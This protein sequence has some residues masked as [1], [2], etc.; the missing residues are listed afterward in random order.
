MKNLRIF[1]A[2]ISGVVIVAMLVLNACT[3]G[4]DD[5]N[6]N[7]NQANPSVVPATTVL[8]SG[9]DVVGG[10]LYAE[11][12]GIFY[13]G[14]YAG[15]T[16]PI[17]LGDYEFR[18]DI[19]NNMWST[20]YRAAANFADAQDIASKNGNTNLAG[21]ALAM[22]AFTIHHITDM[23]GDV[24]YSQA[25]QLLTEAEIRDPEYDTQEEVYNQILVDLKEANSMLASGTGD[26]GTGDFVYAGNVSKWRKF[27][28][29]LR[30]RLAMRISHVAE[31]QAD[32]VVTEILGDPATYPIMENNADNAY[33]WW[34]GLATHAERWFR[35]VGALTGN[36]TTQYRMNNELITVL[37]NLGDPRLP[38]YADLNQYGEYNGYKMGPGQQTN[39]ENGGSYVSHIGNRFGNNPEGFSPFMNSAEVKFLLA[40]IYERNLVTG[41]AQQAYE[42]GVSL[43]LEENGLTGSDVTDYLAVDEVGWNSGVSSNL[44]KIHLQN[45]IALFKN[46]V[47]AWSNVR[48]TDVPLIMN[49]SEDF[50][51]NHNRPPLRLAYP[52]EEQA[53]NASFPNDIHARA[54]DTFYGFQVWWDTRTGIQ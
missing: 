39:V 27:I 21:V 34:P 13:A 9:F 20:M 17:G 50:A 33:I 48:R 5:L 29:S 6:V 45:W 54:S 10:I 3:S 25:F 7:P 44:Y 30:L 51:A 37:E 1:K 2:N 11:R 43:S 46:S 15:H 23:W 14:T 53:V 12:M 22:K 28:N 18:V 31:A 41:N 35:T 49:V 52:D 8:A 40:E 24:P 16:A 32:A 19:N 42:A 4:F 36:K 26:L 38:V 47:N